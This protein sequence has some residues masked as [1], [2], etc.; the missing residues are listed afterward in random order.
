MAPSV[1]RQ[2]PFE[3]HPNLSIFMP[4]KL[5]ELLRKTAIR[6]TIAEE[7]ESERALYHYIKYSTAMQVNDEQM[8]ELH[9]TDGRRLCLLNFDLHFKCNQNPLY[10]VVT[11]DRDKSEW[12]WQF[13]ACVDAAS[14]ALRFG[15]TEQYLPLSSR[16]MP[17]FEALLLCALYVD[18][19]ELVMVQTDWSSVRQTITVREGIKET[20]HCGEDSGPLRLSLPEWQRDIRVSMSSSA[21][22]SQPL[23]P[24]VVF[25]KSGAHRIE[26]MQMVYVARYGVFVGIS[27]KWSCSQRAWSARVIDLDVKHIFKKHRL[28]ALNGLLYTKQ[29]RDKHAKRNRRYPTM[30]G[31]GLTFK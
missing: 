2:L 22:T 10:V 7:F 29:L 12:L 30:A 31:F 13:D 5:K 3:P 21:S 14:L 8:R 28:V 24:V 16:R 11:P 27:L 6:K 23:F 17:S 18:D 1:L 9:L 19:L 15:V 4:E 26:W 25:G 20:K